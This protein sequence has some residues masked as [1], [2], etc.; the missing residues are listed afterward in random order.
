MPAIVCLLF[1]PN[2]LS[3]SSRGGVD[4]LEYAETAVL[5]AKGIDGKYWLFKEIGDAY[6]Q[7]GYVGK[8]EK[9]LG[10][11]DEEYYKTQLVLDIIHCPHTAK[12]E[13]IQRIPQ[14]HMEFE[15]EWLKGDIWY[16]LIF[17]YLERKDIINA[18]KSLDEF[19]KLMYLDDSFSSWERLI[20]L[21]GPLDESG[22]HD[23]VD[24][25]V[26]GYWEHIGNDE[27]G[28]SSQMNVLE[29]LYRQGMLDC[30]P[31][32]LRKVQ[33]SVESES[34][35]EYLADIYF[36]FSE[37]LFEIDWLE[38]G[39]CYSRLSID[40]ASRITPRDKR[41]TYVYWKWIQPQRSA[42]G[43]TKM[44]SQLDEFEALLRD[45]CV[46]E[47]NRPDK[48]ISRISRSIVEAY[49]ALLIDKGKIQTAREV[50]NRREEFMDLFNYRIAL[51]FL[52]N[53]NLSHKAL[54]FSKKIKWSPGLAVDVLLKYCEHLG[55]IPY[56]A[57]YTHLNETLQ[58]AKRMK[59][60]RDE[61]LY[62][63]AMAYLNIGDVQKVDEVFSLIN[64]PDARSHLAFNVIQACLRNR[65]LA[66]AQKHLDKYMGISNEFLALSL[67][68]IASRLYLEGKVAR[69]FKMYKAAVDCMLTFSTPQLS[70]ILQDYYYA[71]K[72]GRMVF[73][74]REF[75]NYLI[76][77]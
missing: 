51:N 5:A 50:A 45:L 62:K 19:K 18:K 47:G 11:I 56:P 22:M 27:V 59:N 3:G 46:E 25:I 55:T 39:Y 57:L 32:F 53:P 37:T 17:Y 72:K 33:I 30:F 26:R 42:L 9:L 77:Q 6:L 40:Q 44:I 61:Y 74:N 71:V 76:A 28:L 35:A 14:E 24:K 1:F 2:V 31:Q 7:F 63:T 69:A 65:N 75:H 43:R 13:F 49:I 36:G 10:L 21:L 73:E 60:D 67:S 54:K 34:S 70:S 15:E 48:K 20:H 29:M 66:V 12:T 52:D 68:K 23:E 58:L 8:A 64:N 38:E 41:K 4:F 16:E